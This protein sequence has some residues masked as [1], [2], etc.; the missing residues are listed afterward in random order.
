MFKILRISYQL[1]NAAVSYHRI[2]LYLHDESND[3]ILMMRID[4]ITR[5]LTQMISI[6]AY[7]SQSRAS[8]RFLREPGARF[9]SLTKH[10][11]SASFSE[12]PLDHCPQITPLARFG[13][14]EGGEDER[15]ASIRETSGISQVFGSTLGGR[16]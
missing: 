9:Q 11:T 8:F 3:V 7:E 6:A 16:R 10:D 4:D 12:G 5:V 13:M 1:L 2:I 14:A 15:S